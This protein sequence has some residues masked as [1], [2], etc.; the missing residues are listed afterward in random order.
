MSLTD[1]ALRLLTGDYREVRE[2]LAG[3]RRNEYLKI[4]VR[5]GTG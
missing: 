5:A 1:G 4:R 3:P 2:E